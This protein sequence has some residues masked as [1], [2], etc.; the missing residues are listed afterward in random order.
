M[1]KRETQNN[2]LVIHFNSITYYNKTQPYLESQILS[3]IDS[4][5]NFIAISFS[6]YKIKE[7]VKKFIFHFVVKPSLTILLVE[8]VKYFCWFFYHL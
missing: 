5:I 2:Y 8:K 4:I 7:Y 6:I 1:N 3:M